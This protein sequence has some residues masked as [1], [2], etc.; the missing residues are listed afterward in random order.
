MSESAR[1]P[2]DP[3]DSS[4]QLMDGLKTLHDFQEEVT[5]KSF[6]DEKRNTVYVASLVWFTHDG[7]LT[8]EDEWTN[9]NCVPSLPGWL[10]GH[11]YTSSRNLEREGILG[12]PY[13]LDYCNMLGHDL[14]HSNEAWAATNA[15]LKIKPTH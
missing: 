10:P 6:Q 3:T 9:V 11:F 1:N 14:E 12:F 15:I 7:Y 2:I 4:I 5:L 13:E 8:T